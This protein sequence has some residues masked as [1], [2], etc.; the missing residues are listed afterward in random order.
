[1]AVVD[2]TTGTYHLG[3]AGHGGADGNAKSGAASKAH[4][5]HVELDASV[6]A[7]M[8]YAAMRDGE[9]MSQLEQQ[10]AVRFLCC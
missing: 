4:R 1:M 5:K 10:D 2:P 6:S 3:A 7:P 8:I 9:K